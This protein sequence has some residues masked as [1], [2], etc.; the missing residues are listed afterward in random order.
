MAR[1]EQLLGA[2]AQQLNSLIWAR[3][4]EVLKLS[5]EQD[6]ARRFLGRV[7]APTHDT[8]SLVRLILIVKV[9]REAISVVEALLKL[10]CRLKAGHYNGLLAPCQRLSIVK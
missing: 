2:K 8:E 1:I 6:M 5:E 9:Y 3:D 4:S 10:D 7:Q